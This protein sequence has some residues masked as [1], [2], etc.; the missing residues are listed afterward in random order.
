MGNH[1]LTLELLPMR[2]C[3]RRIGVSWLPNDRTREIFSQSF[4][5]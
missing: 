1:A 3:I 2:E 4:V 5:G